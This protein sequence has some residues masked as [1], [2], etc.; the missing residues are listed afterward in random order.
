MRTRLK[1]NPGQR[2]TKKLLTQDGDRL[3][4]VRYRYDAK[5][6]K[7]F[8]T[9]ELIVEEIAW[10]PKARRMADATLVRIQV[11]LPEV[12]VR[13]QVKHA[14]GRWDSPRRVWKLRY[15]WVI[16]LGLEGRIVEE[17]GRV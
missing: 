15:D 6:K 7:R 10:E 5:Q 8:K 13:R 3:V 14:G 2:G 12:E 16:A 4:C 17:G 1:L 11:A 9:V